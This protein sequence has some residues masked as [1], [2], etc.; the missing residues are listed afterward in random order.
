M[1]K[2]NI[3]IAFLLLLS[4]FATGC[5][6]SVG[7]EGPQGS[8]GI[9]GEQGIPGKDGT[10]GLDGSSVI[11]GEGTPTKTI[12][13][14]GDSY[15]DISTWNYYKKENGEWVLKGN[16]KGDKGET[17]D[18][19]SQGE[20]GD[21]GDKGETGAT[22]SQGEKG[23]KGD[24]GNAGKSAYE[25][26]C[27]S[28]PDYGGTEEEWLKDLA[29]GRLN[30]LTITFDTSGGSAIESITTGFGT[31][32]SVENPTK[33]GFDFAGWSLNGTVIDLNT[34]VF[35]ADS[36]LVAQWKDAKYVRVTFDTN[37][38]IVVPTW[39]DIEYG[40]EYTLP[41]PSKEFQ[42]FSAWYYLDTEIP[43][44]GT[45]TYTHDSIE[46]TAKYTYSNVYID[47]SVDSEY[48]A[49][50]TSRVKVATGDKYTLPIP[51]SIKDGFT[52]VGWYEGDTKI[53]DEEG[54]SLDICRFTET[55]T[56]TA[57]YY[58]K[59][60]TIYEFMELGGK[61]L[62]GNYLITAD[63]DF[64]GLGVNY[65]KS[66]TGTFDGGGHTLSNFVLSTG[67][68][69]KTKEYSGLFK[70]MIYGSSVC[71]IKIENA[72]I[73]ESGDYVC[74]LVG[75]MN[76][77]TSI[78]NVSINQSFNGAIDSILV[79][80]LNYGKSAGK[81]NDIS[82]SGI[83]SK[84]SGENCKYY[85]F[86]SVTEY[87]ENASSTSNRRTYYPSVSVDGFYIDGSSD[88]QAGS[89]SFCGCGPILESGSGSA[90]TYYFEVQNYISNIGMK[91]GFS[92]SSSANIDLSRCEL[93][94]NTEV[95][96]YG[97]KNL[98]DS[99]NTGVTKRWGAGNLERCIDAG[100]KSGT[101]D[102][103]SSMLSSI[104]LYPD[105][106]DNY[107]YWSS[108]GTKTTISDS[109]LLDKNMFKSMLGFDE[110]VWDLD[111]IDVANGKYP[112]I[113]L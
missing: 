68:N 63:L 39:I 84:N 66:L 29:A 56:L 78:S 87:I 88:F 21:K 45:W 34:Y 111:D 52:F 92:D 40:K 91:N 54:N 105:A 36:T 6:G 38:G 8:Q 41:T 77:H 61:D 103:S 26:Y 44:S 65:I 47:L 48:G 43:L 3:K 33:D 12:G 102:Y 101:Y 96:F 73:S 89:A 106:N 95:A 4:A 85:C 57:S 17:G 53:T 1:K 7:P 80:E 46:L 69:D 31:Y 30:R 2:A 49:V 79:G 98:T 107:T 10:D 20:K 25:L 13:S 24:T 62:S 37:G 113:R 93:N 109:T 55:T 72:S 15:I 58:Q 90:C 22:G 59:I 86:D 112:R 23:D 76:R 64:K 50:D 110:S 19:G 94:G 70:Q 60:N 82:I 99:I 32:I 16:I 71:N 108:S 11:S 100:S 75:I 51:T 67:A 14:D 97:V 42:T 35:F 18:T 5:Q 81:S 83:H 104:I 9:Q 74:G 28:H 27:E